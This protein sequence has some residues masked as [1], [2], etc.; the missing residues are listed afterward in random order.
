MELLLRHHEVLEI[1][2]RNRVMLTKLG[3]KA[4]A[5]E[6]RAFEVESKSFI[7]SDALAQLILISSLNDAN[8]DLT[9]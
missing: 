1:A 7:K 2:Q 3:L 9:A 4:T 6:M 8:V 5:D